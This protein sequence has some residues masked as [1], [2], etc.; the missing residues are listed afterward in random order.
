VEGVQGL[1]PCRALADVDGASV[2]GGHCPGCDD[3]SEEHQEATPPADSGALD[4]GETW[5]CASCH[6][7]TAPMGMCQKCGVFGTRQG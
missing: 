1:R 7:T 6:D 5:R 4:E 3:Y 2:N